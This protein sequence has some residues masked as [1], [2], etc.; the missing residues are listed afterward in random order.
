MLDFSKNLL[1]KIGL[2]F[3]S[4]FSK[5]SLLFYR[6]KE[7]FRDRGDEENA[8][9]RRRENPFWSTR[10]SGFMLEKS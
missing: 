9:F 7:Y 3:L 6:G 2:L 8:V 5:V 4:R 10:K 1:Q